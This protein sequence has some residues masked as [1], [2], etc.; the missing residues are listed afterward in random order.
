LRGY[1]RPFT[2]D[3]GDNAKG[4]FALVVPANPVTA[5]HFFLPPFLGMGF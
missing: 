4:A 2:A 3:A 5:F 1:G